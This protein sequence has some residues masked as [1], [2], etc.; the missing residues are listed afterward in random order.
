MSDKKISTILSLPLIASPIMVPEN[1]GSC[2]T[3]SN[4]SFVASP[5][6]YRTAVRNMKHQLG[7][8]A[9]FFDKDLSHL[10]FECENNPLGWPGLHWAIEKMHRLDVVL[11]IIELFPEEVNKLTPSRPVWT[12]SGDFSSERDYIWGHDP[13]YSA[14]ELAIQQGSEA[15]VAELLKVGADP[16]MRRIVHRNYFEWEWTET[17][18]LG[19]AIE[20]KQRNII[21]M[22][23]EYGASQTSV[24]V[25]APSENVN[26]FMLA[27]RHF[28]EDHELLGWLID[29][30][31]KIKNKPPKPISQEDIDLF[32]KYTSHPLGAGAAWPPLHHAFYVQDYEAAK[33]LFELGADSNCHKY[34]PPP[35][36]NPEVPNRPKDLDVIAWEKGDARFLT[37]LLEEG[38]YLEPI[39]L[40][41][42]ESNEAEVLAKALDLH[43]ISEKAILVAL[44][45][46][47]RSALH[48][49]LERNYPV[50]DEAVM[51]AVLSDNAETMALFLDAK[52]ALPVINEELLCERPKI[53]HLFLDQKIAVDKKKIFDQAIEKENL[54]VL[55]IIM[56]TAE[57]DLK[58]WIRDGIITAIRL[59][60]MAAY[61]YLV[62]HC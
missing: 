6:S 15:I 32:I 59:N 55:R 45:G 20:Q 21:K 28:P 58:S 41:S 51:A 38:L 8:T 29:Q 7:A 60:K 9:Q 23:L 3:K 53:L 43:L 40:R 54:A 1:I 44:K 4:I 24:R 27:M 42:I 50:S 16:N 10:I 49:L 2:P 25:R 31:M 11:A 26:A 5:T 30:G 52:I 61:N 12:S 13:G 47:N 62:E 36:Y 14:L 18:L 17:S 22:L 56:E 48:A 57:D 46:N 37:L 35:L 39:F 34:P 19:F 33:R